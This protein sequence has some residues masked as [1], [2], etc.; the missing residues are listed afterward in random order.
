MKRLFAIL[1]VLPLVLAGCSQEDDILPQQQER[2]VSYLE[3]THSPRLVAEADVD[4]GSEQAYYTTMGNTVYRYIENAYNPDRLNRA[5]V[6]AASTATITFRAYVFDYTNI[7]TDGTSV[8][9]PYY[10]NDPALEQVYIDSGLTPGEWKF[11]PLVVNMSDTNILNGV[12]LALLG[13]REGDRV[14]A[15]MTYNMGYG[16]DYMNVVPKE[17]PLAFFFTV[18]KVQ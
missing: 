2:I 11:L 5:E 4:A 16:D 8:T 10:S 14:E 13:C 9:M 12:R 17:S 18:D 6:T 7:V 15:Y 1:F 3:S